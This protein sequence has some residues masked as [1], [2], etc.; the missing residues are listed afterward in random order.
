MFYIPYMDTE[1]L[2]RLHG[3]TMGVP[4]LNYPDFKCEL[5][6]GQLFTNGFGGP[7]DWLLSLEGNGGPVV[8]ESWPAETTTMEK[9]EGLVPHTEECT[10]LPIPGRCLI[11]EY[12]NG[13]S[14]DQR[15]PQI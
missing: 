10:R 13:Q 2:H 5:T 6:P 11:S 14:G 7:P 3:I 4:C 15:S 1:Q 8:I 12:A 9:G